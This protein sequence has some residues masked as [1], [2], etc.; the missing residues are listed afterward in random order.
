ME[1]R[2]RVERTSEAGTSIFLGG[3]VGFGRGDGDRR[4]RPARK[5]WASEAGSVG[6]RRRVGRVSVNREAQATIGEGTDEERKE[7][8]GLNEDVVG[9]KSLLE[10]KREGEGEPS[11]GREA[12]SPEKRRGP[13]SAWGRGRAAVRTA[14]SIA[15]STAQPVRAEPEKRVIDR[16]GLGVV[17]V[18]PPMAIV[19][20]DQQKA[21]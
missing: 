10:E 2:A 8:E 17:E 20:I 13:R 5:R 21:N 4:L 1:P 14:R 15:P 12:L 6:D 3:K 7:D 16:R 9:R 11:K 18:Q 19:D